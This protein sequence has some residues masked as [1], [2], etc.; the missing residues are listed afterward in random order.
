VQDHLKLN[1]IDMDKTAVIATVVGA[2]VGSIATVL[3]T[4]INDRRKQLKNERYAIVSELALFGHDY[5][6]ALEELQ[7]VQEHGKQSDIWICRSQIT[8]LL[9]SIVAVQ[10]RLWS[11]FPQRP[12]RAALA[13]FIS[14]CSTTYEYLISSSRSKFE[15]DN[16]IRWFASGLEE[17]TIQTAKMAKVPI[18]D[19]SRPYFV[20]FRKVTAQDKRLLSFDDEQPPW[21]FAVVF[22]FEKK[23]DGTELSKLRQELENAVGSLQCNKHRRHAHLFIDGLNTTNYETQIEAC[24]DDF[25]AKVAKSL[26]LKKAIFRVYKGPTPGL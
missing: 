23:V 17:V 15:A 12:L 5:M 4:I 10:F 19:P 24:C 16:A 21:E 6:A 11:V 20:G 26:K 8:R 3:L 25:A 18:K 2:L 1:E 9:G 14:R 7:S 22:T 13:R